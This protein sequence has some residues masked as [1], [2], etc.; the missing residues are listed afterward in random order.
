MLELFNE[1]KNSDKIAETLLVGKNMV[2]RYPQDERMFDAYFAYLCGF[3]ERLP[4]LGDRQHFAQLAEVTLAFYEENASLSTDVVS[5]ISQYH[6]QLN[7]IFSAISEAQ[8]ESIKKE[9]YVLQS[10]NKEKLKELLSLKDSLRKAKSQQ[11]FDKIISQIT[12]IDGEI[13]KSVLSN[14]QQTSYDALTKNLTEVV[15]EK[16]RE[17][18]RRNNVAYNKDAVSS[19]SDAFQRFKK[20]SAQFKNQAVLFSL[21]SETLFKYDASRLFNETLIYYNHVYSY[22][23]AKLDDDGKL[24]LTRFSIECE[25]KLR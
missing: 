23:F 4:A 3:A 14:E 2:N 7:S 12:K 17:F 19:F 10:R 9:S 13:D 20:D 11:T 25:K 15:S 6:K 5:K 16:M 22:I 18:E 1:Y 24:A 21:V 8:S